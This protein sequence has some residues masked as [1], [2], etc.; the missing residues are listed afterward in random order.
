[1][2][3]LGQYFWVVVNTVKLVSAKVLVNTVELLSPIY[4]P[5][6]ICL[7]SNYF[8]TQILSRV[9]YRQLVGGLRAAPRRSANLVLAQPQDRRTCLGAVTEISTICWKGKLT[10]QKQSPGV[11]PHHVWQMGWQDLATRWLLGKRKRLPF[12]GGADVPLL[13]L[14][15]WLPGKPAEETVP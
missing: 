8:Q 1:M 2:E 15:L 13:N 7:S 3:L 5:L 12:T 6:A 4:I 10:T 11:T 9:V 14:A